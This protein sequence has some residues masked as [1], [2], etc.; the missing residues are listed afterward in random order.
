VDREGDAEGREPLLLKVA[1]VASMLGIGRTKAYELIGRG[2]LQVVHI[3]GA[4]RVPV[5]AVRRYVDRLM[6][7]PRRTMRSAP[8]Q[9]SALQP[10]LPFIDLPKD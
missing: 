3:D 6:S 8:R 2:D 7:P 9:R 1:E 4:A 10:P 5:V